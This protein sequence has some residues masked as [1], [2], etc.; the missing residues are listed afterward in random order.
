MKKYM[1]CFYK[2]GKIFAIDS[3]KANNKKETNKWAKEYAE[4]IGCESYEVERAPR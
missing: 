3:H 1:V 2:E 4:N